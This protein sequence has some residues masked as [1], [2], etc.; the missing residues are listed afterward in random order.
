MQQRRQ[1]VPAMA[2]QAVTA[3]GFNLYR[4]TAP[5]DFAADPVHAARQRVDPPDGVS[6]AAT[7]EGGE[8]EGLT[9]RWLWASLYILSRAATS[10]PATAFVNSE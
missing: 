7:W 10:L 2:A 8:G 4:V 6:G 9:S 1:R 3:R 5:C